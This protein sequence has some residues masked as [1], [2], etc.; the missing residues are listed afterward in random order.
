MDERFDSPA[1]S[2]FPADAPPSHDWVLWLLTVLFLVALTAA[3]VVVFKRA[4]RRAGSG[5]AIDE[6]AKAVMHFL[7]PGAKA[8]MNSQID[9]AIKSRAAIEAQFG[10]TL[11]LS[12]ALSKITGQLNGAV[13]G[14]DKKPYVA[15]GAGGPAQINGGTY[16]NISIGADGQVQPV[17][18]PPAAAAKAEKVMMTPEEQSTA[19]WFAVQ[20]LFD[21]WK[22]LMVVT[23]SYRAALRQLTDSPPWVPPEPPVAPGKKAH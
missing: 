4:E 3:L 18:P 15:K 14:T 2:D 7:S 22:N 12:N 17:A 9:M 6:R 23:E 19:I 8:P 16:I 13:E 11:K 10:E 20:K 5:A 1:L 21:Y